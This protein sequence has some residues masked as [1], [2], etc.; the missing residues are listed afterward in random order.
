MYP[1][2]S[3]VH[4]ATDAEIDDNTE[5]SLSTPI[6]GFP[7]SG[8]PTTVTDV[9][10]G[11]AAGKSQNSTCS[12]QSADKMKKEVLSQLNDI[13]KEL[14]VCGTNSQAEKREAKNSGKKTGAPAPPTPLSDAE[15]QRQESST[16]INGGGNGQPRGATFAA[17]SR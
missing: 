16:T 11:T 10:L 15:L 5:V 14:L 8:G 1:Q 6:G 2:E 7:Q 4:M 9:P 17:E 12:D 3:H 13:L